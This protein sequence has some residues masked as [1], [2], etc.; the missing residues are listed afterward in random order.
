M[1]LENTITQVLH[2]VSSVAS[3]DKRDRD[4]PGIVTNRPFVNRIPIDTL[5]VSQTLGDIPRLPYPLLTDS[6]S[7]SAMTTLPFAVAKSRQKGSQTL[8]RRGRGVAQS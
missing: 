7:D 5:E 3:L 4:G 8:T 6:I 1:G 2:S